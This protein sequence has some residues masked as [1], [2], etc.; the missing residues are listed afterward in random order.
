MTK[1]SRAAEGRS[2]QWLDANQLKADVPIWR[3]L[4]HHDLLEGMTEQGPTLR[5]PSPFHERGV[6]S[7]NAE[8]N[9]WND[10]HGRPEI[11]GRPVPGNVIGLV[12]ALEKVGF[13]RA[14][15]ILAERYAVEHD[16]AIGKARTDMAAV[17]RSEGA[18]RPEEGNVPFGRELQGLRY[19]VPLLAELGIDAATAK[20]WGIGLAP[21]GLMKGR[22]AVP[23]RNRTGQLV[24]YAGRSLK[25]ND[26]A[27][28]WRFPS[29]FR[30]SL[31]LFGIDRLALDAATRQAAKEGG[32]T[33]ALD[34]LEVVKLCREGILAAVSPMGPDLSEE[35]ME[36]LLDPDLNPTARVTLAAGEGQR[37]EAAAHA[38]AKALLRRAWL[39]YGPPSGNEAS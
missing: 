37:G 6:L 29:G 13:R 27:G 21:R 12:M 10:S 22:I 39:R 17:L 11:D 8:K 26:A 31:E 38:W 30:R 7:V 34:P 24:A 15:E 35:Q 16:D 9:V 14:L 33:L 36:L 20:A 5:G 23:I 2:A 1:K 25:E 3:V 4:E 19:D 28:E 32:L 18:T